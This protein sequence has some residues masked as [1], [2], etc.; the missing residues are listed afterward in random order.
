VSEPG[1]GSCF[2]FTVPV[3]RNQKLPSR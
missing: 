1:E 3:W 2:Y